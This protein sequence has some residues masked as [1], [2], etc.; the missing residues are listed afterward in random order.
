MRFK[1]ETKRDLNLG[2]RSCYV[3]TDYSA[4]SYAFTGIIDA[5]IKATERG[6]TLSIALE[7]DA[8]R[9]ACP[10][11]DLT[12]EI[13]DT[14]EDLCCGLKEHADITIDGTGGFEVSLWLKDS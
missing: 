5:V 8:I 11:L 3:R 14:V 2:S 6:R 9:I 1:H 12:P 7:N 10:E 4:L 13:R